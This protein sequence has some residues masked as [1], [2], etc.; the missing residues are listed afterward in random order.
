[1]L[2]ALFAENIVVVCSV[3][4]NA[5]ATDDPSMITVDSPRRY[6]M[7]GEVGAGR[8]IVVGASDDTDTVWSRSNKFVSIIS[9]YAPGVDVPC[10][11]LDGGY[12]VESGTSVSTAIIS[13]I[14]ATYL[15]RQDLLVRLGAD[16][17]GSVRQLV[18]DIAEEAFN[19][20]AD[21]VPVV[22]TYNYIRCE[23]LN[24]FS[25]DAEDDVVSL[26]VRVNG[27]VHRIP[28]AV[29]SSHP[30]HICRMLETNCVTAYLCRP[31]GPQPGRR[32]CLPGLRCRH[33]NRD[34]DSRLVGAKIPRGVC[35][36]LRQRAIRRHG[37]GWVRPA[38]SLSPG[39]V[40]C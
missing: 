19:G 26:R 31:Q 23:D 24:G 37:H 13:G 29:V 2:P 8:L 21:T 3:G 36:V 20:V 16:F 6:A 33:A 10:A 17:V 27:V 34:S 32:L 40:W 9:A 11:N 39:S 7:A 15:T 38:V 22:N 14:I 4:N 28:L 12:K 5:Y 1:M 18:M 35:R 30:V 25:P